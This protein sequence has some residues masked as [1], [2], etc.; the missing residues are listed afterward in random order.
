MPTLSQ[1]RRYQSAAGSDTLLVRRRERPLPNPELRDQMERLCE[2]N[3]AVR[4]ESGFDLDK[5]SKSRN[6]RRAATGLGRRELY[7]RLTVKFSPDMC[8][9]QQ[10]RAEK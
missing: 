7:V 9:G 6:S 5:M 8:R 10:R 2:A 4:Q 3:Q 1:R